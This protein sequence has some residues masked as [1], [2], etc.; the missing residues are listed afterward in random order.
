MD[1]SRL[2][3]GLSVIFEKLAAEGM[4]R[5]ATLE[6]K[7][8]IIDNILDNLEKD[9]LIYDLD[10][11]DIRDATVQKALA[12]AV[13]AEF[14]QG[15]N[16][17]FKFDYTLLFKSIMDPQQELHA[18]L[19]PQLIQLLQELNKLN[20]SKQLSEK[21]IHEL[22]DFLVTQFTEKQ[23]V[24]Q[25]LAKNTSLID[26]LAALFT[27]CLNNSP[28]EQYTRDLY[29][30]VDP[31]VAGGIVQPVVRFVSNL[32]G[33]VDLGPGLNRFAPI[34]ADRRLN[35]NVGLTEAT[36]QIIENRISSGIITSELERD[37][38]DAG[39]FYTS[40][41]PKPPQEPR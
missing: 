29:G 32:I 31:H 4:I 8:T 5:N 19:K 22:A 35:P 34:N 18:E 21:D 26:T 40:M 27:E 9:G 16:P 39:V 28:D 14:V 2:R 30:G 11:N 3:E 41:H 23:E 38:K 7:D 25:L 33:A 6:E 37:L 10:P 15:R 24:E 17:N 36:M 20:P 1:R 12:I 13:V